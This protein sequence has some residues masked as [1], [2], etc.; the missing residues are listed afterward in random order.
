[1]IAASRQQ[2]CEAQLETSRGCAAQ[3]SSRA[4]AGS[5]ALAAPALALARTTISAPVAMMELGWHHH[6][7]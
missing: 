1:L 6:G 5:S 4:H 3:H 2:A 7:L